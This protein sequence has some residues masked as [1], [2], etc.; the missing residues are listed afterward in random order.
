MAAVMVAM[1]L[2]AEVGARLVATGFPL[3]T[4]VSPNVPGV[5]PDHNRSVFDAYARRLAGRGA[6]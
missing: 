5:R 3:D 4:F 1:S 2:V 6:P